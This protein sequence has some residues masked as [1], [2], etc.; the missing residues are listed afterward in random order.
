MAPDGYTEQIIVAATVTLV[1]AW[2]KLLRH[3]GGAYVLVIC[4]LLAYCIP[5]IGP[6][7][8]LFIL[9]GQGRAP[10]A[11]QRRTGGLAASGHSW[12]RDGA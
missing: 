10:G 9:S 8:V 7:A 2:I 4:A 3:D 1:I 12:L 5:I 11:A 6:I